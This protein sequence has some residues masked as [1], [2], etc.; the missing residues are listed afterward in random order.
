LIEHI[1]TIAIQTSINTDSAG[2]GAYVIMYERPD[3]TEQA[4][5]R[6]MLY[7]IVFL[8]YLADI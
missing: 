1:V 8:Q 3:S 2:A 4:K 6:E 5:S 7:E